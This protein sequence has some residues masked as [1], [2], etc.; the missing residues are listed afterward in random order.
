MPSVDRCWSCCSSRSFY[1]TLTR[2]NGD[3]YI[4]AR[5]F[6]RLVALPDEAVLRVI[7]LVMAEALAAGSSIAEA[8]GM[9]LKPDVARWWRLD[10]TF[11]DLLKDRTAIK[12]LLSEV[13]GKAIA[14]ANLSE[15]GRVQKKIIYDCLTGERRERVEGFV[16]RYMA[17]PIGRY[18]PA[19]TLQIE[20][21]WEAVKPLFTGE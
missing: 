7:A 13:A 3:D 10:D 1:G 19:K 9:V 18:D 5:L 8:A 4:A 16:P 15:P 11:L 6:A 21:D 12:A 17:F 20:D 14:D 2:G